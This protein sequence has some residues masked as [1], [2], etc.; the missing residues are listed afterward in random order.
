IIHHFA[1]FTFDNVFD[2]HILDYRQLQAAVS[3]PRPLVPTAAVIHVD[4]KS[5][6]NHE[7][8]ENMD[9]V[10]PFRYKITGLE[11]KHG[12]PIVPKKNSPTGNGVPLRRAV[13]KLRVLGPVQMPNDRVVESGFCLKQLL[14][15]TIT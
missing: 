13:I 3:S 2:W 12:N 9:L 15:S 8:S 5:E 14:R 4:K 11:T 10:D 6:G 7:K 1:G